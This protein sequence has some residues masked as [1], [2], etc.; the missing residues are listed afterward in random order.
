MN[1]LIKPDYNKKLYLKP[2][3]NL[4]RI[5]KDS[6]GLGIPPERESHDSYLETVAFPAVVFLIAS[7]TSLIFAF[8][9]SI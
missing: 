5:R 3:V 9:A 1:I 8:T 2:M 7:A 4:K 6:G